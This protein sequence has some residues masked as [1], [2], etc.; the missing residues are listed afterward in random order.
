MCLLNLS[1]VE[2]D[3]GVVPE[4]ALSRD[5]THIALVKGA[6]ICA[7]HELVLLDEVVFDC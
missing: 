1:G 3:D 2:S 5:F 4:V 6:C 7:L